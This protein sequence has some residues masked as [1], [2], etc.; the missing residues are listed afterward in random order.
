MI[1]PCVAYINSFIL[2]EKGALFLLKPELLNSCAGYGL[3]VMGFR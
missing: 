3:Y 2:L 1:Q